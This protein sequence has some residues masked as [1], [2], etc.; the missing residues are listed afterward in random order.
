MPRVRSQ[1]DVI[2]KFPL[3]PAFRRTLLLHFNVDVRSDIRLQLRQHPLAVIDLLEVMYPFAPCD[4]DR[5]P[6]LEYKLASLRARIEI[7]G[8]GIT[9]LI[10]GPT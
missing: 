5:E 8:G 7:G 3:H 6:A 10:L 1:F 2:V 4:D 9:F